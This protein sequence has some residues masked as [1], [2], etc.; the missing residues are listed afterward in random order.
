M[1]D[2]TFSLETAQQLFDS[3]EDFPVDFDIAWQWLGYSTKGNAKRK[4]TKHFILGIEYNIIRS[5]EVQIEGDRQVT[6]SIERINLSIDCLKQ[7]GMMAGTKQGREIRAYFLECERMLKEFSRN[8]AEMVEINT[9]VKNLSEGCQ[10]LE[11]L[12]PY[13]FGL[14]LKKSGIQQQS[15]DQRINENYKELL[16]STTLAANRMSLAYN[17]HLKTFETLSDS[18]SVESLNQLKQAYS[19]LYSDYIQL[20]KTKTPKPEIQT[21]IVTETRTEIMVECV[22]NPEHLKRIQELENELNE[23]VKESNTLLERKYQRQSKSGILQPEIY[24]S[25][26]HRPQLPPSK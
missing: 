13:Y 5:D 7:L 15:F 23:L 18:T 3:T 12:S 1:T 22:D 8:H 11:Q 17:K 21:E 26:E 20:L 16:D 9:L 10:R 19:E 25:R 4:L 2:L 6:R 14:F 24:V